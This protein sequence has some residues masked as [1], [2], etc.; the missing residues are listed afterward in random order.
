M[1]N[2]TVKPTHSL[3][4]TSHTWSTIPQPSFPS[5]SLPIVLC[6]PTDFICREGTSLE[7]RTGHTVFNG[8]LAEVFLSHKVNARRFVHSP[9]Y[10][11][12]STHI[13]RWLMW[14][15]RQVAFGFKLFWPQPTAPWARGPVIQALSA[16][17]QPLSP[18]KFTKIT[19]NPLGLLSIENDTHCTEK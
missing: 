18:Q 6:E 19:T 17:I 10:H 4:Q 11:F 5:F 8:L 3:A 16:K 15:S 7:M 2:Y 13:I 12:I 14:H 1:I 9:W